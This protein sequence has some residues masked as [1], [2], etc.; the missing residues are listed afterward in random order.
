[1]LTFSQPLINLRSE[2]TEANFFSFSNESL[3]GVVDSA[4]K[5]ALLGLSV[6]KCCV[7]SFSLLSSAKVQ[8]WIVPDSG[9][10]WTRP[11]SCLLTTLSE[12]QQ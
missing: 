3:K 8:L 11:K 12:M 10:C 4:Y 5:W 9:R 6:F 1:M 7:L 2:Q